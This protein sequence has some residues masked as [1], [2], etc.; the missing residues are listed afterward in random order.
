MMDSKML[1][2]VLALGAILVA[3]CSSTNA[4]ASAT[5]G[6]K[7]V[8]LVHGAWSNS[9]S[10]SKVIPFLEARRPQCGCRSASTYIFGG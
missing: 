4:Q 9:S 10:W 3:N 7:T 2:T 5:Q 8:V 1:R 6:V